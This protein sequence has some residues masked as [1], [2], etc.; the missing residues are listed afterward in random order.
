[1]LGL[2]AL[3]TPCI[4]HPSP[5]AYSAVQFGGQPR[6]RRGH[7]CA[8]DGWMVQCQCRM[9]TMLCSLTH[10]GLLVLIW[11]DASYEEWIALAQSLHE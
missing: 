2:M 10:H 7:W 3:W 4:H 6:G 5:C 8:L 1:M 11:L 9:E